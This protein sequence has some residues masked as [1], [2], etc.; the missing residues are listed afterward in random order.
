V[1]QATHDKRKFGK[2]QIPK[3]LK[4][5]FRVEIPKAHNFLSPLKVTLVKSR[6][7]LLLKNSAS[8]A[9]P[10]ASSE[11]ITLQKSENW[12]R[13]SLDKIRT[14]LILFFVL[15]IVVLSGLLIYIIWFDPTA[16]GLFSKALGSYIVL[17]LSSYMVMK[18][19]D[20]LEKKVTKKE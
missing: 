1:K 9:N 4:V 15:G 16:I 19:L 5:I 3:K 2:T 18:L 12:S 17:L 6:Y 10:Y 8:S 20:Y 11:S 7:N 14:Y 13:M